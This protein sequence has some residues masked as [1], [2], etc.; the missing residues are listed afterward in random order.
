[1]FRLGVLVAVTVRI[2]QGWSGLFLPGLAMGLACG[3]FAGPAVGQEITMPP[4]AYKRLD[5]FEAHTLSKA[6]TSFGKR[7]FQQAWKEYEAFLKEFPQSK[8]VPF[9]IFRKARCLHLDEKR[10]QAI[11]TYNEVLDFFPNVIEYAAPALYSIGIAYWD[12]GD[13]LDARKAWA[14][15]A[16]DKD[17]SKHELAGDAINRLA[18]YLIEKGETSKALEYYERV[19]A[20]FRHRTPAAAGHAIGQVVA[21]YVRAK[22]DEPKLRELYQ[23]FQTF[24][25]PAKVPDDLS[26]NW[27]YW[28]TIRDLAKRNGRFAQGEEAVADR[29]WKYWALAMDKLFLDNDDFR[30]DV[31]N[32]HLAYERSNEKWFKR[33]DDQFESYQKEGDADR[34]LKWISLYAAHKSKVTQYYQKL[35]FAK[36]SQ[37]LV[38]RLMEI[39]YDQVKDPEMART[40]FRL[41]RL[42]PM[43]DTEKA[44]LARY[45]W[46]RDWDVAVYIYSKFEDAT[47]AKMET[48]RYWY[49]QKA[50]G[51]KEGL[52]LAEEL[53]KDPKY[54]EESMWCR[55]DFLFW[56]QKYEEAITAYR[57]T[58][59][60]PDN[61]WAIVRCY[62]AMRQLA[63]AVAQLTEIENFVLAQASRARLA[64]AH[65]YNEFGQRP[66]YISE[67]R[68][69]MKKYPKS[70][71]SS[72][73]HRELEALGVGSGGG[74]EERDRK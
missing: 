25:N 41:I 60:M 36:M 57:Q 10:Y 43:P 31:A 39:L 69:V 68:I 8:A 24:H 29:Y 49:G 20:E 22:P 67:L 9:A 11:K 13:K 74:E 55:A 37:A 62:K 1:L 56:D 2:T 53:V 4:E 28:N 51:V 15:M 33:L 32:M 70:D 52:P 54:A 44:S 58:S 34:I 16:E 59:K 18:G 64:I 19:G 3:L 48:M 46:K 72:Q 38:I 45:F 14:E 5:Q 40:V 27:N 23:K 12:S 73:A 63:P 21:Y 66:Q 61:L 42:D 30:I 26:K 50:K 65:T 17:Y 71:E 35:D 7:Q 47:F 6:D